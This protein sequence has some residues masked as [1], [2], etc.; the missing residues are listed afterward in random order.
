MLTIM[1]A[2]HTNSAVNYSKAHL[3]TYL[4]LWHIGCVHEYKYDDPSS[5]AN[6]PDPMYRYWDKAVVHTMSK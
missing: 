4:Q 2:M 6:A 1:F 5:P 3:C